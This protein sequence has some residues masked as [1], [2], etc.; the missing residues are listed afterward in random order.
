MKPLCVTYCSG[1]KHPVAEGSPKQLYDS[2]RITHFINNCET[3]HHNWAILSA[4]Y[5]LFFPDEI[6]KNYNVT[7]KTIAYKCRIVENNRL[8]SDRE[9]QKHIQQL[10][11]QVK[12]R[13]L[14]NNIE[15]IVFFFEQ[16]LQR[17]KCYLNILHEGAD[18]C[19]IEHATNN[20]LKQ[21]VT[22]MFADGSGKIKTMDF[23]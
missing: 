11:K 22:D 13:I 15:Q 6:H 21:H 9:S 3:R 4:K 23:I 2:P 14:E 16:P 5:G 7:F 19:E 1:N 8:L 17:R 10:I 18:S 20:E 12:H